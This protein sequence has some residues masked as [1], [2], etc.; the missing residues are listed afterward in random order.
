MPACRRRQPFE[1]NQI[2]GGSV[3][4]RDGVLPSDGC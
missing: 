2:G 3:G 1:G 4:V